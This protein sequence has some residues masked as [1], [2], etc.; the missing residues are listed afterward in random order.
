[1][2]G[3]AHGQRCLPVHLSPLG[4]WIN[5]HYQKEDASFVLSLPAF[6]YRWGNR[7]DLGAQL[8]AMAWEVHAGEAV[9]VLPGCKPQAGRCPPAQLGH[10]GHGPW[11]LVGVPWPEDTGSFEL[12]VIFLRLFGG[13]FGGRTEL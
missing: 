11:A 10:L 13:G 6:F 12:R 1:M 9:S 2:P 7:P 5:F 4:S 8:S 3:S